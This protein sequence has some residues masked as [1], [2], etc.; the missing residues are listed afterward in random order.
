MSAFSTARP[1]NCFQVA[2]AAEVHGK[3][4][5]LCRDKQLSSY[6]RAERTYR[7]FPEELP[8]P[9]P[10]MV[11]VRVRACGLSFADI[12][13]REGTYPGAPVPPF[14]SGYG[15][16]G[17]VEHIGEE[18]EAMSVGDLLAALTVTGAHGEHRVC[19]EIG[20][21]WGQGMSKIAHRTVIKPLK[22]HQKY[23]Q[24]VIDLCGQ[25]RF[26]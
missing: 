25:S 16:V 11:Q 24:V 23:A 6:D 18:I 21:K 13:I 22:A 1:A 15:F 14:T 8:V 9:G 4:E 3:G 17:Y 26:P 12:L 2:D 20:E 19:F 7:R 5:S 10:G